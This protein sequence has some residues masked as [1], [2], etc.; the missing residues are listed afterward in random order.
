MKKKINKLKRPQFIS[1][2]AQRSFSYCSSHP[3]ALC[4]GCSRSW[5]GSVAPATD[6]PM[7]K[8]HLHPSSSSASQ[9]LDDL[10]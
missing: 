3:L 7:G 4:P 6:L 5:V 10:H 9:T 2:F 8:H 1:S